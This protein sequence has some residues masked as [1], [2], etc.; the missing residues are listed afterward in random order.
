[1]NKIL[2]P[3][4][5]T[6]IIAIAG[7]FAFT[8]IDEASTVHTTIQDTTTQLVEVIGAEAATDDSEYEIECPATSTACIILE[9][10]VDNEDT[11]SVVNV[12]DI[13]ASIDGSDLFQ[14]VA[15]ADNADVA[16]AKTAVLAGIGDFAMGSGDVVTVH[17]TGEA[18][19]EGYS[20]RVIA[21][22]DGDSTIT[23][24]PIADTGGD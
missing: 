21:L 17:L 23:V 9:V 7:I 10:Y 1:M 14:V 12:N 24:A 18:N 4:I 13:D 16:A 2:I 3:S 22:V 6:I 5:L 20:I 15:A 19:D 8:P 11:T